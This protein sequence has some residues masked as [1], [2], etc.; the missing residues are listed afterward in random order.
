MT[1]DGVS[2]PGGTCPDGESVVAARQSPQIRAAT[3]I[4]VAAAL[5]LTLD[6]NFETDDGG[7]VHIDLMA[8]AQASPPNQGPP[9]PPPRRPRAGIEEV[10]A[11]GF[12][13]EL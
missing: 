1:P 10:R 5:A 7:Y 12:E 9:G 2:T 13:P 6:H 8:P 3:R 4:G 11:P